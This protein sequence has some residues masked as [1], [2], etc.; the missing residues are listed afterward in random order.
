MNLHSE[1]EDEHSS[2]KLIDELPQ[3]FGQTES[4]D[5]LS[6]AS[7]I[8]EIQTNCIN[9]LCQSFGYSQDQLQILP[10]PDLKKFKGKIGFR[11]IDEQAVIDGALDKIEII[12]VVT[13]KSKRD[14][15][16]LIP[17]I[18]PHQHP[19]QI[20]RKIKHK[21]DS[22]IIERFGE[23][24]SELIKSRTRLW[25]EKNIDWIKESPSRIVASVIV[26]LAILGPTLWMVGDISSKIINQNRVES[27]NIRAEEQVLLEAESTINSV[28]NAKDLDTK[29]EYIDTLFEDGRLGYSFLTESLARRMKSDDSTQSIK[30]LEVT[31]ELLKIDLQRID[32]QPP[33]PPLRGSRDGRFLLEIIEKKSL[34]AKDQNLRSR[35]QSALFELTKINNRS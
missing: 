15:S 6:S 33:L 4:T 27:Q 34:S 2:S 28:R 29:I 8:E 30:A 23:P 20:G 22:Q 32:N 21:I 1:F 3:S 24:P 35:Y 9:L 13:V 25:L 14:R 18:Y 31:E 26:G 10:L 16:E 17:I 12:S 7:K 19:D 5:K 11:I